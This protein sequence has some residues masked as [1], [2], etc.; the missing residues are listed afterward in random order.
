M[1][2]PVGMRWYLTVA[3]V[4]IFL[5]TNDDRHERNVSSSALPIF[6]GKLGCLSFF[7]TKELAPHHTL[8]SKPEAGPK[9]TYSH[10]RSGTLPRPDPTAHLSS[11]STLESVFL[12]FSHMSTGH[13]KTYAVKMEATV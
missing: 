8:G 1:T 3:V 2:I 10:S 11:P 6:I 12:S 5:M 13:I 7:M 9:V 4:C